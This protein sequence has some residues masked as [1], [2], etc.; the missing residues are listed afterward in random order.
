MSLVV[1]AAAAVS[2]T[3]GS[4]HSTHNA[5]WFLFLWAAI[6]IVIGGTNLTRPQ[7]AWRMRR[8]QYKNPEAVAPSNAALTLAR[9]VGGIFVIIGI[10]VLVIAFTKV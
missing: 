1:T 6:A 7:L 5:T 4:T 9:V 3:P 2:D 10:V 8:W